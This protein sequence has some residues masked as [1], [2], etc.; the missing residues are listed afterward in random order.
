M[1]KK[2]PVK[3]KAPKK[4]P[5]KVVKAGAAEEQE[6]EELDPKR[7][8]FKG[9]AI[10]DNKNSAVLAEDAPK[11]ANAELSESARRL[12][13]K[14]MTEAEKKEKED[15]ERKMGR[16]PPARPEPEPEPAAGGGNEGGE[17]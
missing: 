5:P 8:M 16:P 9:L 13:E 10:K 12:M 1:G 7:R 15:K 3:D 17:A 2:G 6:D 4:G 11:A 14:E